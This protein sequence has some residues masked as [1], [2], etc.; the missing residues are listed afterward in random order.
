MG[1]IQIAEHTWVISVLTFGQLSAVSLSL[2]CLVGLSVWVLLQEPG[3]RST[4]NSATCGRSAPN[5]TIVP[6]GGFL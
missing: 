1:I 6:P 5:A 3:L 2:V 4:R